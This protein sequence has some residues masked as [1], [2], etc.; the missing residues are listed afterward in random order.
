MHASLTRLSLVLT[1]LSLGTAAGFA[2]DWP[3]W[4]GPD[5]DGKAAA[6]A[7]IPDA[8]PGEL[9][10]RWKLAIGGG[11][12]SPVAAGGQV[13]YFDEDGTNEVLH[14][15][16]AAT[17]RE[18][19]RRPI[20]ARF[21]DEWGAGPRSTPIIDGDHIYAL[22][23][24]GEFRCLKR[25]DGQTVWGL[26]F[27]KHFGVRFLGSKANE[28]TA[29]RRGNNGSP[30][31]TG[32]LLLL[33]VGGTNNNSLVCVH[34]RTGKVLWQTGEDEAAYS[35]P[36]VATLAGTPQVIAFL[37]DSLL[38]A[39]LESGRPLWRVPLKTN[40]KRHAATPLIHGDTVTV[41][42]HSIGLLCFRI[43][44]DGDRWT[45]ATAWANRDLKINLSTPVR[46]GDH[47]FSQGARR[48]YVCAD[49]RT[50]ALLW[51]QP[52]FG[53]GRKDNCS[54]IAIAD[55]RLLVLAEDGQLVLLDVDPAKYSERGRLQVCG[56]TWVHPA[57]AGGWLY[58]RD[59]RTLTCVDLR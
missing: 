7:P 38:G 8:L 51:S 54:T 6:D 49:A 30:V 57:Y 27:E 13:V 23:C 43:A 42:S 56:N 15:I 1:A 34:K 25:S 36:M 9:K 50:G 5:R 47:L 17:G 4:R 3:Q 46:V 16:D 21:A 32:D 53:D 29:S 52:G 45:A 40:A 31:I 58:V 39:A 2:A 10:P 18:T 26:G 41:N 12:S 28:G 19:W 44:R 22:S 24:N 59:S 48:D 14:L 11:F 33:P 35:S 55:R 37:G 20:A